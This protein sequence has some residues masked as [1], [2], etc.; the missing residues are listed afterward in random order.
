MNQN[1]K[2]II[3]CIAAATIAF[4]IL[5]SMGINTPF[6]FADWGKQITAYFSGLSFDK[7]TTTFW[8]LIGSLGG[9]TGIAAGLGY[10]VTQLKKQKKAI[11]SEFSNF[12]NQASQELGKLSD[13]KLQT[14]TQL[15]SI[16]KQKTDLTQQY[17]DSQKQFS[18]LK[19]KYDT[20][21]TKLQNDLKATENIAAKKA[22]IADSPEIQQ[23]LKTNLLKNNPP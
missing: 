3:V 15:E 22:A 4:P 12:K 17:Q 6:P 20:E 11:T 19:S 16:T 5:A 8:G 2:L 23:L 1:A 14:D 9:A 13:A 21:V 18:E 10:A 7:I